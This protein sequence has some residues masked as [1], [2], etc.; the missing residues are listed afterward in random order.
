VLILSE[1]KAASEHLISDEG[2]NLVVGSGRV[3][4]WDGNQLLKK[5]RHIFT[6]YMSQDLLVRF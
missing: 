2:Y 6:V 5:R 1:L 4:A 3:H